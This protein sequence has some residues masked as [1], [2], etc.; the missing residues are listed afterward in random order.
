MT[1]TKADIA[2]KVYAAH[3]TLTTAQSAEVVE[4]FLSITKAAMIDGNDLL[5]SGFGKFY[6]KSKG[7]HRLHGNRSSYPWSMRVSMG[8]SRMAPAKKQSIIRLSASKA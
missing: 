1:L 5:L 3:P 7:P 8:S 6:A 4:T 2:Q